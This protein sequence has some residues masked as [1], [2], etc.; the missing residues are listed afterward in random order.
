MIVSLVESVGSVLCKAACLVCSMGVTCLGTITCR[1]ASTTRQALPQKLVRVSANLRQSTTTT[2]TTAMARSNRVTRSVT[3]SMEAEVASKSRQPNRQKRHTL[4]RARSSSRRKQQTLT[5]MDFV[6]LNNADLEDCDLEYVAETDSHESP[7]KNETCSIFR[8]YRVK[9]KTEDKYDLQNGE[10]ATYQNIDPGRPTKKRR[11]T[12]TQSCEIYQVYTTVQTRSASRRISSYIDN[13]HETGGP[14]SRI[15]SA[16]DTREQLFSR[17]LETSQISSEVRATG[18]RSPNNTQMPFPKAR[19][20]QVV[21]DSDVN[22]MPPPCTPHKE[23]LK[24]I[25]F[26]QS[27]LATP[28]SIKSRSV[29]K[30]ATQ[31]PLQQKSANAPKTVYHTASQRK[32]QPR[33]MLEGEDIFREDDKEN[34][35]TRPISISP[36]SNRR[37]TPALSARRL[38]QCV[39]SSG[40]TEEGLLAD[41]GATTSAAA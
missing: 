10:D 12:R 2:T 40:E 21:P 11:R 37:R 27:P 22:R 25:P 3:T 26:S 31:S 23:R 16:F 9:L 34:R 8:S 17:N 5:Q 33:P 18:R 15:E 28:W 7:T 4:P 30:S 38:L 13:P 29:L 20:S 19:Q 32:V 1:N 36:L 41:Y 35:D 39:T 14:G 6:S 24:E